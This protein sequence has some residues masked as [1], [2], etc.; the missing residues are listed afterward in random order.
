MIKRHQLNHY[1]TEKNFWNFVNE[2]Q[3][4]WYRRFVK[5]LSPPWTDDLLLANKRFTNVYREL[6]RGTLWAIENILQQP[7]RKNMLFQTI[8]YR[9]L[10]RIETVEKVDLPN[11]KTYDDL[12]FYLELEELK[13]SGET[14]FGAAYITPVMKGESRLFAYVVTVTEAH[15]RLHELYLDTRRSP[16]LKYAWQ[17]LCEVPGIGGF[18]AFEIIN[19]LL[20]TNYWRDFTEDDFVFIGPGA[21]RGL[22]YLR[23]G[24]TRTEAEQYLV[25]L[26]EKQRACLPRNFPYYKGKEITLA[27]MENCCCEFRKY[28][29]AREGYG[30]LRRFSPNEHLLQSMV[31]LSEQTGRV[32]DLAEE[33]Q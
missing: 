33:Y 2:R 15:Q 26:R 11:W 19:D 10:N 1:P 21:I 23:P 29:T 9:C 4:I 32:T 18:F 16:S 20:Y 30:S 13:D 31:G 24:C 17:A 22:Q 3:R 28:W 5:R 14:I 27:N 6:D 7:S 25:Q 12:D 8:A